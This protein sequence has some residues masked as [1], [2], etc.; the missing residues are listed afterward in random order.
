M[1]DGCFIVGIKLPTGTITYHFE[2]QHWGQF[3]AVPE[4]P[5]APKWD[6]AT[7]QDGAS[8]SPDRVTAAA[9]DGGWSSGWWSDRWIWTAGVA[10]GAMLALLAWWWRRRL[11]RGADAAETGVA[12]T[13]RRA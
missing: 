13:S 9:P 5:H 8:A 6:G 2:L 4:L 7:P 10:A 12:A 3:A 11:G 1:F